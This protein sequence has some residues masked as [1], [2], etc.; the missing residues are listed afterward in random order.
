METLNEK[1][2]ANLCNPFKKLSHETMKTYRFVQSWMCDV[3]PD[4]K[5]GMKICD[6]CRKQLSK[7]I[8]DTVESEQ[9]DYSDDILTD[10]KMC[11]DL[12][13]E[14]LSYIEESLP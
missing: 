6:S 12:L 13:N 8:V 2:M 4:I 14:S 10:S 1:V 11:V 5:L 7:E 9:K 3:R